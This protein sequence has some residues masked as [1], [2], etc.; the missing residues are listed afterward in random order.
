MK[1]TKKAEDFFNPAKLASPLDLLSNQQYADEQY[2]KGLQIGKNAQRIY[3]AENDV[4]SARMMDGSHI[5]SYEK[6]GYHAH[7]ASLMKGF[8]D[9]GCFIKVFR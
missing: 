6:I 9:S 2:A 1:T 8:I 5:D 3:I 4:W 7:T